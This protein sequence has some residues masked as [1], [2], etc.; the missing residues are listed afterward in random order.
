[1]KKILK[2]LSILLAVYLTFLILGSCGPFM[3]YPEIKDAA[4]MGLA[5]EKMHAAS[6]SPDR[7]M[8]IEDNATALDARIRLMYRA[9]EEIIIACYDIRDGESTRDI[10]SVALRKA[11]EGVSVRIL[12]DGIS[13]L[14]HMNGDLFRAMAAHPNIDIRTYNMPSPFHPWKFMG[15]MHDKYLI[16]DDVAYILGGRNMFDYFIGDYPTE[17]RSH[18]REALVFNA[19]GSSESSVHALRD[20]FEALWNQSYVTPFGSDMPAGAALCNRIYSELS[21]RYLD[22]RTFKPLLFAEYDLAAATEP[23]RGV[24][25]VTGPTGLYAKEP[26]VFQTLYELM[27][28]A[29]ED[30]IIHSPYAVLNGYME[31]ALGDIS[32]HVPTTIMVNARENGDNIVASRDYTYHRGKVID[33]GAQLLEYAGGESYHGKSIAIDGDISVIGSFNMDLRSAYVDTEIMLVINSEAINAQLRENMNALHA[34]CIS[35]LSRD[36]AIIPE[37]LAVPE[38]SPAKKILWHVL[39]IILQPFRIMV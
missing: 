37:G 16:V 30:V 3:A 6:A 28:R 18:D 32:A 4:P 17:H 27:M 1:L 2:T 22:L 21:G 19:G 35:I 33:T 36:E 20:Y 34:D 10:L 15:R 13:G 5:A 39:G 11:D 24:H 12:A 38:A 31:T 23:T 7:A 14:V 29:E 26:V 25:L 8:I 9:Q